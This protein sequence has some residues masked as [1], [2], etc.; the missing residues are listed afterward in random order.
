MQG[1]YDIISLSGTLLLLDNN[2]SLGIMG[3]LSVL[4]SRPD[5]SNICGVVAEMLKASSPVEL[6]VRRYIPKKEKPMPE[7][8]SSTC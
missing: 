6:L 2:D 4:L 8:P 1:H 3:G 5:G 7:E